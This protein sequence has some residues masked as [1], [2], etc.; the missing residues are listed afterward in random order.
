MNAAQR[1]QA[2]YGDAKTSQKTASQ[3]EYQAFAKI[4]KALSGASRTTE[5]DFPQLAEAL[6]ENIRLWTIVA[7]GVAVE[8][9]ALPSSLRA[10]LP[11]RSQLGPLQAPA[12][13]RRLCSE[14]PSSEPFDFDELCARAVNDS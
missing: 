10:Q 14:S 5:P 6:H 9:N 1:A 2:V 7:A 8:E 12:R 13:R 4:T 11:S 3:V